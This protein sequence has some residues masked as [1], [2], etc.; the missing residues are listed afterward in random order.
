MDYD[1]LV[2]GAGPGGYHA[3]IRATQLGLKV[4]CAEMGELGGVC[5]NIGCI[6]TKA[7]LHAGE[8]IANSKHAAEF[9][10]TFTETKL[11]I[12]KLNGWKKSV[13][14]RMS[15][16]VS[17]LFKANKVTH[18][19]GKASFIDPHTV[20]VGDRKVTALNIIISTGSEPAGLPAFPVDQKRIVDSTGAL[21]V[22]DP[23]PARMLAIGAGAI[24]IEFSQIYNN[25][26]V[27]TKI[28]EF[29]P[30]IVA[31]ADAQAAAEFHKILV[32]QGIE[33]QTS[34]KA[35]SFEEKL[36]GL[37]VELEDVKTGEKRTEV[38]DLILSAVGRR[39]RS[40]GLGLEAAGVTVNERGFIPVNK[41][42]QTNVPHIYA[43]GDVIG[44]PMLAHKAMKEGLVA[45][46]VIAGK[47]SE[48]D[49][50]AIPSVVY[51]APELAWVG[52]TEQEA[53][54]KG[55]KVKTGVF[56]LS[57]S[58]RAVTLQSTDGFVKM[59][60]DADSDLLLGVH[61]VGP[62]ASDLL[63]EAGLALEMA[64]TVSDVSLTIHAHPTLGESV[65]EAAEN[66][67]KQAIHIMNR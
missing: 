50:V 36:D 5:L 22:P 53:K 18:L 67:H 7:L 47:K 48:M 1:L 17:S 31:A 15:G 49:P 8:E 10:L 14:K 32:K 44:N 64:A 28:I 11:D 4:A 45:A 34:T 61:I 57:A 26:G 2:I 21:D 33:I 23:L 56:P 62:H 19:I 35:N 41:K 24:G 63:G 55:Y 46:E 52:L 16:G 27:K 12:A 3:A 58:G 54:D 30:Q 40:S 20:L 51:T 38:F 29:V 59:V 66:V 37:H 13:V 39:P 6:P 25:L 60:A 43:I 65:M 9:G 42:L